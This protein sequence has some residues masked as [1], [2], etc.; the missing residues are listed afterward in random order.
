[1][2]SPLTVKLREFELDNDMFGIFLMGA[3]KPALREM[4]QS[5]NIPPQLE[6]AKKLDQTLYAVKVLGNLD[7]DELLEITLVGE[8]A[9]SGASLEDLARK[10]LDMGKEF[11]P[12]FKIPMQQAM[13]KDVP[14]EVSEKLFKVTDQILKKDGIS[15][16]RE[17]KEVTLTLIKPKDL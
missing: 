14:P 11:Y 5:P 2:F 1:V 9:A 8:N 3:F 13:Q 6:Q 12:K 10:A 17:G 15:V 4:A 7:N 16:T